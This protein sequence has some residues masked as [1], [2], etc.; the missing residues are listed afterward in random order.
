VG[1]IEPTAGP[2]LS[3][4]TLVLVPKWPE[5]GHRRK[6]IQNAAVK[7]GKYEAGPRPRSLRKSFTAKQEALQNKKYERN[8]FSLRHSKLPVKGDSP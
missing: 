6:D 4:K 7:A 8:E 2:W 1:A 5:Y 3:H